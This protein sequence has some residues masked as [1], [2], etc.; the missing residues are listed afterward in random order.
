MGRDV[1]AVMFRDAKQRFD[2]AM[3]RADLAA[4]TSEATVMTEL[5]R[6]VDALNAYH[7]Q[8][9]LAQWIAQARNYGSTPELKD[10]YEMNARRLITTWGGTLNDYANRSWSGLAGEYYAHRWQMYFDAT[11]AAVKNGE[12]FNQ[13]AFDAAVSEYE[14]SQVSQLTAGISR[15]TDEATSQSDILSLSRRLYAKYFKQKAD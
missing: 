5:L 3:T 6:D 2:A 1:L 4:M 11:F 10:Y 12:N 14:Q 9:T 15:T 7:P 13:E 8:C